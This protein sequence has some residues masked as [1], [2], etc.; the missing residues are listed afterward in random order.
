MA[1]EPA[2]KPPKKPGRFAQIKQVF[3]AAKAVDPAIGWWMALAALAVLVVAAI[4]G[5]VFNALVYAL[6][7]GIPLALLAATIVL[8]RRAERAAYKQIEGQPGAVGAALRSIRRGWFIE[9]Q[10]V[11]ADAQRATDLSSAALVYRAV[12]RPGIVLIGEGPSGRAQKL[13]A[14]E[15]RKVERVASGVPVTL[16]RVGESGA[17]EEISIRKLA[18]KVQKL[19]PV[20]TKEEV[21]VVNKRLKSIGG[22]RPPLP[23]GVDPTKVRMDR[24]A[25]RGR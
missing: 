3:V 13:L 5:I 21:S 6:I 12:G 7:L 22:V 11:A 15:R 19:K 18:N 9:E 25:M 10:P 23:K 16:M 24:K 8:S 20:L 14:A 2:T 4:L 17:E 1:K